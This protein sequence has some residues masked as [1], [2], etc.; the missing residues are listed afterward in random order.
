VCIRNLINLTEDNANNNSDLLFNEPPQAYQLKQMGK[1]L[2]DYSAKQW[3]GEVDDLERMP[4]STLWQKIACNR[5]TCTARSCEFYE[6]CAFF[7]SRKKISQIIFYLLN[8]YFNRFLLNEFG[9]LFADALGLANA[10]F[11]KFSAAG[12]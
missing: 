7:K 2:E 12:E 6:E 10:I 9:D 8:P 11:D 5:F 4:D 1:L 3:N